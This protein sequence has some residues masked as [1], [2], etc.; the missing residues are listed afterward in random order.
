MLPLNPMSSTDQTLRR[1]LDV[2]RS[3]VRELDPDAV[4]DRI[5]EEARLATGARYA[6]L[7]VLNE[8]RTELARFITAGMDERARAA[9]GDPPHGRGV[10]G[11]LIADP[12]PVR[13]DEVSAHPQSYGFPSGHPNM[14]AFLGV[15]IMI[16]GKAWG[17]LYLADKRT[18]EPFSDDDQE[19]A[20]ILADLAATAIE[21]ARLYQES[22]HRR[23]QLERAV[24][25]LE[26]ARE[27]ADAA[28]RTVELAVVLDLVAARAQAL[29]SA[30]SVLAMLRG[31]D[32]LVVSA[33]AG[34]A[35]TT[36]QARLPVDGSAAGAVATT[37]Q[38]QRI[39][40]LS[41][42]HRRIAAAALGYEPRSAL[43]APM[44]YRGDIVGVLGAY[45]QREAQPFT[46]QDEEL[47]RTLAASA[48]TAVALTRSV[49]AD[50]LRAAIESSETERRRWARELHD[51]TLQALGG[52]R[53]LLAS[54]VRRG[55]PELMSDVV[56]RA[57]ED[58]ESGIDNLR[59]I[60]AD[61]RPSLLDDLGLKPA[62][63]ALIDRRRAGG[64]TIVSDLVLPGHDGRF[65]I[66]PELETTVYRLVQ[67]ALT[68][69]VKHASASTVRVSVRLSGG[70]VSV[71]V[72]DDGV[73]F[74]STAATVGFGLIGVRERIFLAG[75]TFRLESG[76][77]G[78]VL[79][80]TVPTQAG[81]SP[82]G[83]GPEQTSAQRLTDELGAAR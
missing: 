45:D 65:E 66:A 56:R 60:I 73:G 20:V 77:R 37:G 57:I 53:V 30:R 55:D 69:V 75:G 31:G 3:L 83:S 34:E 50:R 76:A 8:Q 52:L 12:A 80:A 24:M 79:R 68:N 58:I 27:I 2:G 29:V 35:V 51:E 43:L 59:G 49:E 40:E 6:A 5:L 33:N 28:V 70:R 64:L 38:P 39:N 82:V 44:S 13:L 36:P 7:G 4:L 81:S 15:P 19:V 21:N 54:A 67:E 9:I 41:A 25:G 71:E 17:N 78:T 23:A 72:A 18:G 16:R 47:L 32:E 46:A 62:I 63:E 74:D 48:A 61:L 10:L 14:H 1:L 22:E 11:V 26:A 42:V